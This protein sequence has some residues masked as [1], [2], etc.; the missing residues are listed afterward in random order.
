[1]DSLTH[2]TAETKKIHQD[3]TNTAKVSKGHV[4]HHVTLR[5]KVICE[6]HAFET[7]WNG[8]PDP[9]NIRNQKKFIKIARIEAKIHVMMF[10]ERILML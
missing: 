6:G 1:M 8:F 4:Q 5:F 3:S 2:K 7:S 9:K 10:L